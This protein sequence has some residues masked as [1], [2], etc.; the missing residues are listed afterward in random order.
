MKKLMV[1]IVSLFIGGVI[2]WS[3]QGYR[4]KKQKEALA[5]K[6]AKVLGDMFTDFDHIFDDIFEEND[7]EEKE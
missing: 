5:E 6:A 3:L 4:I 1:S 7:E 2:G